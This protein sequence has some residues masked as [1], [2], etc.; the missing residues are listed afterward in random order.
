MDKHLYYSTY[1]SLE[2]NVVTSEV[3]EIDFYLC[4]IYIS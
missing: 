4:L 2:S 1:L 3:K